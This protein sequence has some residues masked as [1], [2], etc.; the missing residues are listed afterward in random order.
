MK[1]RR[2]RVRIYDI[3]A[4]QWELIYM[5]NGHNF[6]FLDHMENRPPNVTYFSIGPQI[7]PISTEPLPHN[8]TPTQLPHLSIQTSNLI[9][10]QSKILSNTNAQ[11]MI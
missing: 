3:F 5:Y 4:N 7:S 2:H 1:I 9:Q 10:L 8:P 6:E 11:I